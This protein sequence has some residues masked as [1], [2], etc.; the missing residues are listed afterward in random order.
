MA[1]LNRVFREADRILAGPTPVDLDRPQ[2]I[3]DQSVTVLDV[4]FAV[5]TH[6]SEHVGQILYIAKL[7]LGGGYRVLSRAHKKA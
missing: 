5:A 3:R 4:L 6:I 2:Q 7:R 1:E